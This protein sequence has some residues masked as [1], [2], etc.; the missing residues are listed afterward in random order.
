MKVK[1]KKVR[2]RSPHSS[3]PRDFQFPGDPWGPSGHDRPQTGARVVRRENRS[4]PR[5]L[6]CT[7][8]FP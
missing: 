8:S 6:L 4:V 1:H 7:L 2:S 3:T 5:T